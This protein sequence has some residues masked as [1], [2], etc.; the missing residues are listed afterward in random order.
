MTPTASY[1]EETRSHLRRRVFDAVAALLAE[2]A[3]AEVTMA[4]VAER[5]GVSRQTLYNSFGSRPELAQAFVLH[6][7]DGLAAIVEVA[8]RQGD[9]DAHAALETALALFFET[10]TSH[11]M[12]TAITTREGNEELLA[13]V[14]TKGGP[15][16]ERITRSLG[17][18]IHAAWPQ[19]TGRDA[20]LVAETLVRLAISHAALPSGS[21][22]DTA[23]DV[24]RL[25]GPS[26]DALI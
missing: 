10:A 12:V 18:A 17:E 26:I 6:Q 20:E 4:E 1:A 2:H 23:R 14:T 16:L 15:L 22:E 5:A 8:I 25:L 9:G 19:V 24:V 3:W 21:P 13:M 11:P 7:A